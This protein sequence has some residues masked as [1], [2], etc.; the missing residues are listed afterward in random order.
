[1]SDFDWLQAIASADECSVLESAAVLV[2]NCV[3]LTAEDWRTLDTASRAALTV[4]RRGAVAGAL[5][6]QGRDLDAARAYASIDGGVSA[7]RLM[8][9]AAGQGVARALREKSQPNG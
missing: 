4:A 2:E 7:A 5:E 9:R 6:G 1:V 8:A 3:T